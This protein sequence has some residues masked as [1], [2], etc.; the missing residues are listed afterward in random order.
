M[1]GYDS[2][3][4]ILNAVGFYGFSGFGAPVCFFGFRQAE[5]GGETAG[6]YLGYDLG[7]IVEV[8]GGL[9]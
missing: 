9:G 7:A 8:V 5:E 3:F 1:P 2:D 6:D 4:V